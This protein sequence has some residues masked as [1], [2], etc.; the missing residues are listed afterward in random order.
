M[1]KKK[2]YKNPGN[3]LPSIIRLQSVNIHESGP[4]Q[5]GKP[6]K[7]ASVLHGRSCGRSGCRKGVCPWRCDRLQVL[8][9]GPAFS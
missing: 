7:V 4:S 6:K 9:R 1:F 3:P 8:R 5:D 2:H